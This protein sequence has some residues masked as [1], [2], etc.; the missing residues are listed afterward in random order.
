MTLAETSGP[1]GRQKEYNDTEAHLYVYVCIGG[2]LF[3]CACFLDCADSNSSKRSDFL[4]LKSN[5]LISVTLLHSSL[6][7]DSTAITSGLVSR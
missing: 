1:V 3:T 7:L 5:R 6:T 2:S 4:K